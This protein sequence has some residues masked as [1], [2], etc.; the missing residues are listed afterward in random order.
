MNLV[1]RYLLIFYASGVL[2]TLA[3]L[4]PLLRVVLEEPS[5]Q[6]M[7]A[8]FRTTPFV[9]LGPHINPT[10]IAGLNI[11]CVFVTWGAAVSRS[12]PTKESAW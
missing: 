2:I 8:A 6:P 1:K 11:F 4:I 5:P 7:D 12:S 3:S 9:P 10:T